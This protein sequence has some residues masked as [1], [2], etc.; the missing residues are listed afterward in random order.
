MM[1]QDKII[2]FPWDVK[3][4]PVF[5]ATREIEE[6]LLSHCDGSCVHG[7]TCKSI[8]L[9]AIRPGSS[10]SHNGLCV[11][12]NRFQKPDTYVNVDF[13]YP[14]E[15][16]YDSS[17]RYGPIVAFSEF[18]FQ[19]NEDRSGFTQL[20]P[21]CTSSSSLS[22]S[23]QLILDYFEFA[24]N[25]TIAATREWS[26]RVCNNDKCKHSNFF[27][28]NQT[29]K[30]FG[31]DHVKYSKSEDRIVCAYCDH[32]VRT[33]PSTHSVLR[34]DHVTLVRCFSCNAVIQ[35][36]EKRSIQACETCIANL[37]FD[38]SVVCCV[39]CGVEN[40]IRK[41]SKVKTF[42][43]KN[44]KIHDKWKS[45]IDETSMKEITLCKK[46]FSCIMLTN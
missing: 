3:A 27:K 18:H 31:D 14:S 40:S 5:I 12:C 19:L 39:I 35:K 17:D 1:K 30:L 22:S 38:C 41:K 46:H 43:L 7:P 6:Q 26:I 36:T 29:L 8:K 2:H 4:L 16:L 21:K 15:L 44:V 20:I 23:T 10:H 24:N 33:V 9:G 25:N 45:F 13:E 37:Q 11:L 32:A 34:T 42:S 28:S